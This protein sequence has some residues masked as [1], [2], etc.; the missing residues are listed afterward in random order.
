MLER[1]GGRP[2]AASLTGEQQAVCQEVDGTEDPPSVY[3][4]MCHME[5]HVHKLKT[6]H[7]IETEQKI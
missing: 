2:L 4:P 5:A 1:P 7:F 3:S 6:N